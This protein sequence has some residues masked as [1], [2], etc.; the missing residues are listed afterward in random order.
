MQFYI[1]GENGEFAEATQ[2]QVDSTFKERFERFKR[3]ESANIRGEV[4]TKVREELTPT[5]KK[6][7]EDQI[8][9]EYQ[10]K[11]EEFENK[12]KKLDVQVRQKTIAAEYGFKSDLESFLGEGTDDEMRAKADILKNSASGQPK[13]PEKKTTNTS[14]LG[15]VTRVS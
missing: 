3:N 9:A 11:L 13:P 6:E 15:I 10:P 12:A 8:K 1:K 14:R 4:E 5:L 7:L 2:D